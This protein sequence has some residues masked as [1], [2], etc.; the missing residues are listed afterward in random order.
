MA[1]E[2]EVAV[3][4]VASLVQEIDDIEIALERVSQS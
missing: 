3:G 2:A 1:A 4:D